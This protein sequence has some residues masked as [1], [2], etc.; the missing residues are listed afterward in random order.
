[1][2]FPNWRTAWLTHPVET[3]GDQN[4]A[5]FLT[6]F[7]MGLSATEWSAALAEDRHVLIL[8]CSP[9]ESTAIHLY[10]NFV[11]FGRRR[12]RPEAKL[13]VLEDLGPLAT[14]SILPVLALDSESC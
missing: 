3:S 9:G 1:M 12:T 4:T 2:L 5:K 13:A 8:T 6:A 14:P 11:K 7:G 10:H